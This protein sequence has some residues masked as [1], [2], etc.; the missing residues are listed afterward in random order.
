MNKY[1][2]VDNLY[3][4][5]IAG[6]WEKAEDERFKIYTSNEEERM[7]FSASN[8][9]GEGKKPSINEIENVVD[10]MFAGFDERYESCN[11]KEVSSSYI[12]QGFKNGEDY[13]YYLFTVIDTVDGNHLLVALHLMD[14]LC[15]YNGTRKA[16]LVDV[17]ESIRV[18]S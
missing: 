15:D 16:L 4:I 9:E 2:L 14:G 3:T 7:I 10:D 1:Y 18:L 5:S 6:E 8:Y 13:E 12:Y 11:D 17:M